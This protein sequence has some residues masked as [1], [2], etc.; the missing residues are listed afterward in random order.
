MHRPTLQERLDVFREKHGVPAVD[1][2]D[3]LFLTRHPAAPDMWLTVKFLTLS[4]GSE[5][6]HMGGRAT[7]KVR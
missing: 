5:C 1:L 2:D 4:D 6:I 3:N 7:P